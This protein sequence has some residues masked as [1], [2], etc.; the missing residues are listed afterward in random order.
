[1]H[2]YIEAHAASLL[3][4]RRIEL[5][6]DAFMSKELDIRPGRSSTH[7]AGMGEFIGFAGLAQWY[8]FMFHGLCNKRFTQRSYVKDYKALRR[9]SRF[10]NRPRR[11]DKEKHI[12]RPVLSVKELRAMLGS[13][14]QG[15][16]NAAEMIN[17]LYAELGM[18][19]GASGEQ[20]QALVI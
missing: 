20:A 14:L 11:L 12:D 15:C 9:A 3:R 6:F 13:A 2:P 17:R 7:W 19:A 8:N 1:V 4:H 18:Q 5:D 10:L 16:W